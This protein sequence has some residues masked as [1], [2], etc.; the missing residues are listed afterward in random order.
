VRIVR[1]DVRDPDAIADAVKGVDTVFHAAA[2]TTNKAPS[3]VHEEINVGGT[4][5]VVRAAAD[6]GVRRVVHASSVI[7]YG[8][9]PSTDVVSEATALDR[10]AGRW[11]HYQ[12]T[13]VA[14]EDVARAEAAAAQ[15]LELVILRFGILYGHERPLEPGA[16]TIGQARLLMGGGRNRLPFTHVDDAVEAMLLAGTVDAAAGET[17]NVVGDVELRVREV[18][19]LVGVGGAGARPIGLPRNLLLAGSRVLERRAAK[20]GTD[21]PPRLST[22]V[23][24]SATRDVA[25]DTEKAR[26]EL[27]W[28]PTTPLI[29]G[30]QT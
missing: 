1:G 26:R 3:T 13:K 19:Q 30:L 16:V 4:R 10:D 25:Y 27:G 11:D 20:S 12:R 23:V 15:D 7:V 28:A 8:A 29:I 18:V 24:R 6:A 21:V 22:F 2:V 14:A 9:S 5:L 17:Y